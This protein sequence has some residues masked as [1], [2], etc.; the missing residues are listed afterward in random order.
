MKDV[1][2]QLRARMG[3]PPEARRVIVFG[4]T[5]H[6]DPNWLLTSE[7]YYHRRIRQVLDAAI[8]ELQREPRR[9]FAVE[10]IFFLKMY[11]EREPSRREAIRELIRRRS[12]RLTGSGITTPDTNLPHTEAI[13]RDYLLG[14]QWLREQ[15]LQCEPRLAYLPD[16]FGYAPTVPALL[17]ALGYHQAGITRIDGMFFAGCDYRSIREFPLAGSSAEILKKREKSADFVWR[18]PDGSEVLCHWNAFGYFQ[19]DMLAH[20]GV[21]RWM[22]IPFGIP[23]RTE[24]QVAGKIDGFVRH[25]NPIART[26]YL[27][28][29]IGCDFNDPIPD[30]VSLLDRYNRTRYG[31]T[32]TWAVCAGMDDYLD[33]VDCHRDKLP[34]LELDPNPYWMGF[35]AS[36]PAMKARVNRIAK[37]LLTAEKMASVLAA[38]DRALHGDLGDAW[39]ILALSNHHDFITGTSPNRVFFAE[40]QPALEHAEALADRSLVAAAA[41]ARL[42]PT[43]KPPRPPA[44]TLDRGRLTV[45]NAHLRAE[46][47]ETDGGCL[48]SLKDAQGG[49]MLAGPGFDLVRYADSGGLWRLGHEYR[50]GRFQGKGCAC[51]STSWLHVEEEDGRLVVRAE[52]CLDGCRFVRT[53]WFSQDSPLVQVKILGS[54][55]DRSTVTCR[56]PTMLMGAGLTMDVPGDVVRRPARKLYRPTFWPARSFAHL[57]DDNTGRG[58]AVFLAGPA[59]VSTDGRGGIEWITHRNAPKERAFGILPVMAHPASGPDPGEYEFHCAV[60]ATAAGDWRDNRLVEHARRALSACLLAPHDPGLEALADSLVT[61]DND[62]VMVSAVKPSCAGA[63]LVVRLEN[64]GGMPTRVKL[65]REDLPIQRATLTDACERDLCQLE[66]E[67]GAAL[68]PLSRSIATVRLLF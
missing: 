52:C 8:D 55:P 68:V 50:G 49:E 18:A 11:F 19:G 58:L 53:F 36:R 32:G 28:C 65:R 20:R 37:K 31:D 51:A 13:L 45:T 33:L 30:L 35:Y 14:Q 42:P 62:L 21:I 48:V 1:E 9:V 2:T 41:T 17:K 5:S 10:S 34:V 54:A 60:L 6:W 24:R 12:L 39:D 61:T 3:I 16:D 66:L 26:P 47:S 4:E 63:G 67:D 56:L 7:Q 43:A 29:P 27:F 22:G 46:F 57:I 44:W 23:W 25:L 40:Q 64:P 59:A 38:E 15:G